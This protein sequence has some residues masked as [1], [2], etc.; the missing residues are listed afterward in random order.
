MRILNVIASLDPS[1]GGPIDGAQRLATAW[2]DKGHHVAFVTLD[3]STAS[4]IVDD[5][6]VVGLGAFGSAPSAQR[7]VLGLKE[8][9][10][11]SDRLIPWLRSHVREYDV[12][13]VHALWN[14]STLAARATLINSGVPYFI[15]P[16][17]A[18]D[19]WFKKTYPIKDLAKTILWPFNEGKLMKHA[20]GVLF[21]TEEEQRLAE[22]SYW[23]YQV[24]PAVIGFGSSENECPDIQQQ[25]DFRASV[26]ALGDRQFL[27]F[28]SRIHPK[29][30]CD[31]LIEGFAR[32]ASEYPTLDLVFAGP[33]QTGW[34]SDLE[35]LAQ[36]KGIDRRIHWTGMISGATKW[37]AYSASEAFILPSHSE[38]FGVVVAEALSCG[39][40]ALISDKVN[41]WR[42]VADAGAGFVEADT[43]DGA[44]KLIRQFLSLSPDKRAM[45]TRSARAC[46]EQN[47]RF[48][49]T[50]ERILA[51]FQAEAHNVS[52]S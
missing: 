26:P 51:R 38:N 9:F 42:E 17:G 35:T 8:R 41:L 5:P 12:V 43:V 6:D 20:A 28:L 24:K 27:L 32:V 29:K 7:R 49:S 1:Y 4:Y 16:H 39:K 13:L 45:M 10:G 2:R 48:D 22:D 21:T 31:L 30:G 37:G 3:A 46:F 50:A 34:Q 14:F 15:F 33:D 36:R 11:Y 19:P 23:P 47:F 40:P 52:N 18:L 25:R 44:E